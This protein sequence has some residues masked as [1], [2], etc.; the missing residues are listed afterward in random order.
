MNN[1]QYNHSSNRNKG[2][3]KR[4]NLLNLIY[5]NYNLNDLFVK[6]IKKKEL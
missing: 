2:L 6:N 4:F 5:I 3:L 1:L